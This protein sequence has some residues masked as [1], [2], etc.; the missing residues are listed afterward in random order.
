MISENDFKKAL[1]EDDIKIVSL[2]DSIP[3]GCNGCGDCCI[4]SVTKLTSFDLYRMSQ[5]MPKEEVVKNVKITMGYN[6]GL[7]VVCI[8]EKNGQCPFLRATN[9][10]SFE[11]KLGE[12]KPLVCNG[13]F[14]AVATT[15]SNVVNFT[16]FDKEVPPLEIERFLDENKIEKKTMAFLEGRMNGRCHCKNKKDILVEEY[17]GNRVRYDKENNLAN[18][19]TMMLNKFIDGKKFF[20]ILYMADHSKCNMVADLFGKGDKDKD[21]S[22]DRLSRNII[23]DTYFYFDPDKP[24]VEQALNQIYKLHKK[25]FPTLRIL[26]K[27]LLSVYD[28]DGSFSEI[29]EIEEDELAQERFDNY[30]STNI[31][32]IHKN[33]MDKCIVM[34][35]EM[36]TLMKGMEEDD[37]K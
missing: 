16:P 36:K 12:N 14:V 9:N 33:F 29:L 11:C 27:G 10:G 35:E 25:T 15:L 28:V 34:L 24:F 4:N 19:L 18:F 1:N 31:S 13:Q 22:Y 7:P 8:R 26:Y 21:F 30:F 6:S 3:I 5:V 20:K 23:L 2:K 37:N 32:I 17:L